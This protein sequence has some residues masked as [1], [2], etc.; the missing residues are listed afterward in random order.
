MREE[1]EK[2]GAWLSEFNW[3]IRHT[4]SPT[5]PFVTSDVPIAVLGPKGLS[6]EAAIQQPETLI[7]FPLVLARLLDWKSAIL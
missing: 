4:D 6:L 2:G 1:V 3:A 7:F 5:D